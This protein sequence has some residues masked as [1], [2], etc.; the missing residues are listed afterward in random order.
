MIETKE[1]IKTLKDAKNIAIFAHRHPDADAYGSMFGLREICRILGKDADIYAICNYSNDMTKIF[2]YDEIKSDFNPEAYDLVVFVDMHLQFRLDVEH[3]DLAMQVE[4]KLCIDHHPI[5]ETDVMVAEKAYVKQVAAAC[6]QILCEICQAEN[7]EITPKLAT[8]LW[9]GLMGDT[10][11]FLNSNVTPEVFECAKVL[12]QAGAEVQRVYEIMFKSM[13]MQQLQ[14]KNTAA[15]KLVLREN[16]R[17]AYIV[18]TI[19]DM[20]KLGID[21]DGVKRVSDL[22]IKIEGVEAA[23]LCT[24]YQKN[25]FKIS[26]RS[27]EGVDVGAFAAKNGGGGHVC[28]AAFEIDATKRQLISKL[29]DWCKEILN[30]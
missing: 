4:N 6:S 13:T 27:M 2:N 22:A 8:Y 9:A 29:N 21:L 14:V 10:N 16:G 12:M 11:R 25:H 20:K 28:A 18:F 23:F 17:S 5:A 26:M 7:I 19:K 30:G 24:E 3:V 1:I 15:R